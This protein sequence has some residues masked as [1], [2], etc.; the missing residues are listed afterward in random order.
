MSKIIDHSP[1]NFNPNIYRNQLTVKRQL[2]EQIVYP[3]STKL[4]TLFQRFTY[5]SVS[6]FSF[7]TNRI[8][9]SERGSGFISQIKTLEKFRSISNSNILIQGCGL[10]QEAIAWSDFGASSCIGIDKFNFHTAW[11]KFSQ[12]PQKT[13]V[14]FKQE[15]ICRTKLA[16]NS[17]DIIYSSAVWE[18]VQEFDALI[19]E[20]KRLIKPKGVVL[21]AFGPLWYT[22]SGDHFSSVGGLESG[23]NHLLLP[24]IDYLK[25]IDS[26]PVQNYWATSEE[27]YFE[28]RRHIHEGLFSYLKPR[29]YLQKVE[30]EFT[31]L[32]T[33]V[34]ISS[35]ALK[36]RENFL[37]KWQQILK[38]DDL[39]EEDLLLKGLILFLSPL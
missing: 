9:F 14:D 36:F 30:Q 13:R 23:F 38:Q 1:S 11:E 37:S 35:E 15:D 18:H 10:G 31:R 25:W 27:S 6:R 28:I 29:E 32:Y 34:V 12:L 2:L 19:K 16:N 21:S 26:F 4:T 7:N 8:L 33:I 3:I 20:T 39:L 17:F 5:P 22:F 24:K